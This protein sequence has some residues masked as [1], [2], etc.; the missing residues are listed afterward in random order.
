MSWGPPAVSPRIEVA[1]ATSHTS[2]IKGSAFAEFLRWCEREHGREVLTAQLSTLSPEAR[3]KL[4]LDPTKESIG[5]LASLWYDTPAIGGLVDALTRDASPQEREHM[6]QQAAQIVMQ[7]TLRGIYRTLFQ[8][9]ATPERYA[10][11]A[12]R[13]WRS[14]HDSGR[15]VVERASPNVA[16]CTIT[17]WHGHHPFMCAMCR[18]S[19]EVIYREMGC[20]DVVCVREACVDDGDA[21]CR[22][23]TRWT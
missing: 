8:W 1:P 21:V 11:F 15:M 18:A 9:L 16:I 12:D 14:Y 20:R 2:H 6:A 10:G 23:V 13:L 4:H 19:A 17:D 5:I 3:E 22:F 7:R